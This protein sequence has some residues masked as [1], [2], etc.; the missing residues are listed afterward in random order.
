MAASDIL[1]LVSGLQKLGVT[2]FKSAEF[3]VHLAPA[4][5]R[6][7]PTFAD[8]DPESDRVVKEE[9]RWRGYVESELFPNPSGE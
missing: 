9:P 4:V 1:L 2:Y 3:E 7:V 6:F 8:A 5:D